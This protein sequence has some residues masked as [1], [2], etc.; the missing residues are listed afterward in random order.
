MGPARFELAN[1]AKIIDGFRSEIAG[2]SKLALEATKTGDF[3]AAIALLGELA[4]WA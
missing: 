3:T 2:A 4:D 1:I